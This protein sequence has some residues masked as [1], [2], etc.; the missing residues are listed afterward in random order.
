MK[1]LDIQELNHYIDRLRTKLTT[2]QQQMNDIRQA[3]HQLT[4]LDHVARKYGNCNSL[5]FCRCP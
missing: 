2:V 1:T 5:F 4:S 3:V